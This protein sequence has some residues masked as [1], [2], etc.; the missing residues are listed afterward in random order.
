MPNNLLYAVYD[1]DDVLHKLTFC[2][3]SL[4]LLIFQMPF[5]ARKTCTGIYKTI[6][7]LYKINSGISKLSSSTAGV[8]TLFQHASY[9]Q[10]DQVKMIYL[11]QKC[12]T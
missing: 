6:S 2:R 12:K 11:L 8:L 4:P 9:L 7:A 10:N 5:L 3:F 1:D